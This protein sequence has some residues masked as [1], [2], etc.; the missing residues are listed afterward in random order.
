MEIRIDK[1]D[2]VVMAKVGNEG[3]I[4]PPGVEP[5]ATFSGP[6]MPEQAGGVPGDAG[7]SGD[8]TA[9]MERGEWSKYETVFTNSK[10][11][12][13]GVDK[14]KVKRVV[15]EMSKGSK[16][17]A[18]E[19]RKAA[20]TAE[21]IARMGA[22]A[23]QVAAERLAALQ[24]VADSRVAELEATR[25]LRHTWMHVDMDAFYAA[26][27][28]LEDPSLAHV[29]V[30]VG[31]MGMLSTANYEARKY[32]VRAAMPGFIA[33]R[34][35]PHLIFVKPHFE[36]YAYYSGL[37]REVL[38]EYDPHLI[39]RS[40]DEAYLNLTAAC[41]ERNMTGGELAEEIRRR[42]FEKTK[43]TCSAGIAPNRL[44]AKVC[45]DLNKPNG[46]F[47]LPNDRNEVMKFVTPL[48]IRKVSGIGKVSEQVLREALGISTCGQLLEQ[49][50]LLSALYSKIAFDFFLCVGLGIG[51]SEEAEEEPRKSMSCER[52]FAAISREGDLLRKLEEL[53]AHL[54][55]DMAREGLQGKTLTL[56]LKTTAFEVRSR[57]ATVAGYI[58]TKEEMLPHAVRL[59]Q[60]ELPISIR[61]MG[62]R[63]SHFKDE[64]GGG[65]EPGQRTLSSFLLPGPQ[66]PPSASPGRSTPRGSPGASTWCQGAAPAS[67]LEQGGGSSSPSPRASGRAPD[68]AQR[69]QLAA[70]AAAG[71]GEVGGPREEANEARGFCDGTD[72]A[73]GE[74][75]AGRAGCQLDPPRC[76]ACAACGDGRLAPCRAC[77]GGQN[78]ERKG[79]SPDG[80]PEGTGA[81]PWC[82]PR[83]PEGMAPFI[84]DAAPDADEE[85][86]DLNHCA[87][88]AEGAL[89]GASEGEQWCHLATGG[90]RCLDSEDRLE[91]NAERPWRGPPHQGLLDVDGAE[92]LE[93]AGS[94]VEFRCQICNEHVYVRDRQEHADFHLALSLQA[95]EDLAPA[96]PRG[97]RPRPVGEVQRKSL[98]SRPHGKKRGAGG[99]RLGPLDAFVAKRPKGH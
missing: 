77:G 16:F 15:Y 28:I 7:G 66:P 51:G 30:G 29:P 89:G 86:R 72:Q 93:G 80:G 37:A 78:H 10:A 57:A 43:L 9:L 19:E 41:S 59:L 1:R 49:R 26:V 60:A 31:G 97:D 44:L 65:P 90:A 25:D 56:K 45:S 48:P 69:A 67:P 81:V 99:P 95:S 64:R 61:L 4:G 54:V 40:M 94:S 6:A 20:A 76:R 52:T 5:P 50:A 87:E 74:L 53:A 84:G 46:Q 70:A 79:F 22:E 68:G 55:E 47:V 39:A 88:R 98:G 8:T 13:D 11:G 96:A 27:E 2:G 91:A 32:G 71:A 3:A 21:R 17:F 58:A 12:M 62:L 34:L 63:I 24:R 35:C 38:R 36:K 33:K 82:I 85:A 92:G 83:E 14:E 75:V 42:V 23:A 73:L 18:N